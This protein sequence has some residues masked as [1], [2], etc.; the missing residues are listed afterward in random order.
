MRILFSMVVTVVFFLSWAGASTVAA[1]SSEPT[2]EQYQK[3]GVL[4]HNGHSLFES[5]QDKMGA[6]VN[7]MKLFEKWQKM[8]GL[9]NQEAIETLKPLLD[10]SFQ[11]FDSKEKFHAAY[12]QEEQEFCADLLKAEIDPK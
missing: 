4:V 5:P 6:V 9:S 1:A 7:S 10:N 3:C 8:L 2:A 12:S 11:E